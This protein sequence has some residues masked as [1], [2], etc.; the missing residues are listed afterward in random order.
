MRQGKFLDPL[1]PNE[2]DCPKILL[3]DLREQSEYRKW[4]IMH[5]INFPAVNIQQDSVFGQLAQFKNKTNKLI[6]VYSHDERHGTHAAKVIFEKGYDNI[7]L[8]TGSICVFAY[9]NHNLLEG[10]EIPTK[11]EL[12]QQHEIATFKQPEPK[13]MQSSKGFTKSMGLHLK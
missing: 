13:N 10:I 2:S 7:Y 3:L 9:E 11:K 12:K 6:V 8:L 1:P 5:A 4:H